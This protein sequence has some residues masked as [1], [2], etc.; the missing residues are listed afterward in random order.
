VVL[1]PQMAT[2]EKSK[3]CVTTSWKIGIIHCHF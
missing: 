1:T 2:T 3:L